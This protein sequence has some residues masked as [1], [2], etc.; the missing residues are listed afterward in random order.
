MLNTGKAICMEAER[1]E[2]G[3]VALV[4]LGNVA[5]E[6]GEPASAGAQF[7]E[8]REMFEEYHSLYLWRAEAGLARVAL[9]AG[10]LDTAREQGGSALKRLQ[11]QRLE[12]ATAMDTTRIDGQLRELQ[13][14]LTEIESRSRA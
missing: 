11:A 8:A 2:Y 13:G 4:E 10:E 14:L 9:T 1:S 12:L 3:A 6:D 5:L 7:A